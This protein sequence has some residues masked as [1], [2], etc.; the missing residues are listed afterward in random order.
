L[1]TVVFTRL[2]G[3]SGYGGLAALVSAFLILLVAGSAVQVA[4]ARETVLGGLGRGRQLADT[5]SSW[6][7]RLGAAFVVLSVLSALLR[8]PLGQL[9]GVPEHRWAAAAIVPTGVLW[10]AV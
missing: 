8:H 3:A 4:A 10:M 2:L 7:W 1:F 5:L 6:M 9:I